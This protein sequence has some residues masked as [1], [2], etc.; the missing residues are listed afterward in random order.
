MCQGLG[1]TT[2]INQMEEDIKSA[3]TMMARDKL[4]VSRIRSDSAAILDELMVW[5]EEYNTARGKDPKRLVPI[6]DK[7]IQA[8]PREV[9]KLEIPNGDR[10]DAFLA[11][12]DIVH[13]QPPTLSFDHEE[14]QEAHPEEPKKVA[15]PKF[16]WA[17]SPTNVATNKTKKSLLDIQ[18]E[19]MES[20]KEEEAIVTEKVE[21]AKKAEPEEAEKKPEESQAEEKTKKEAATP[22]AA[23]EASTTTAE[24][25]APSAPAE[26]LSS[27]TE[28]PAVSNETRNPLVF[29][30][31]LAPPTGTTLSMP[32]APFRKEDEGKE[33]DL[34]DYEQE[35]NGGAKSSK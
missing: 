26:P 24:P 33:I 29:P 1:M 15:A 28:A 17:K 34:G 32:F 22:S 16:T 9:S 12:H 6:S 23:P 20:K 14:E 10:L 5:L 25:A 19:E 13:L 4:L 27:R 11:I 30:C 21:E 2:T 8:I 3:E 7:L 31:F 35:T 18:K